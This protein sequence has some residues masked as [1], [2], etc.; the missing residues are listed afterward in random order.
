MHGTQ[1]VGTGQS[2]QRGNLT[3][4]DGHSFINVGNNNNRYMLLSLIVIITLPILLEAGKEI[5]VILPIESEKCSGNKN[6]KKLVFL[7]FL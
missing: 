7:F 5:W 2:L 1:A 6:V 3:R 4:Q